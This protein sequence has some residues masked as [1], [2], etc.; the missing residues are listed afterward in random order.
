M[1]HWE[2]GLN[3]LEL[4]VVFAIV[5]LLVGGSVAGFNIYRTPRMLDLAASQVAADLRGAQQRARL[6]RE[7]YLVR[8]SVGSGRYEISRVGGGPTEQAHLPRG[9][10]VVETTWR[11]H[12]VAF[13]SHGNPV[14]A[15]T[16]R[17]RSR[18]G[19]RAV[20]VD[21]FGRITTSP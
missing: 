5:G 12:Q 17:V 1:P 7:E 10:S 14:R 9:V 21:G 6:E 19:E 15:G 16:V 2:Q 18:A 3:L 11:G 4:V 13:S 20:Q 8:F